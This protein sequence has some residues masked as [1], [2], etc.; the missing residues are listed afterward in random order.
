MKNRPRPLQS[1]RRAQGF[2]QARLAKLCGISAATLSNIEAG[3]AQPS[4]SVL[5]R[6]AQALGHP[7]DE[8]LDGHVT[9]VIT[10]SG[11]DTTRG[12]DKPSCK[13]DRRVRASTAAAGI[14][15]SQN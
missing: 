2:T 14:D 9:V 7:P 5:D 10:R 11:D 12:A 4:P 15:A 13:S 3:I 1:I 8:L 6:L